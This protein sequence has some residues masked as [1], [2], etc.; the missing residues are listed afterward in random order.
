LS[1]L[2]LYYRTVRHLRPIQVAGRVWFNLL[3]PRPDLRAAPPL[4][5]ITGRYAEPVRAVPSLVGPDAFR[6]LNVERRC[7]RPADWQPVDATDLW[8]YNLH[9]FDDL[10]ARDSTARTEWHRALLR[11]WVVENPPGEGMAWQPYPVSR[12]IVNWVKAGLLGFRVPPACVESLAVQ[13]R[14]LA[15][16]LEYH[17]LGNHLLTNAKALLHAGMYFGGREGDEWIA[18]GLAITRDQVA[19]QVLPDGAHFELSTMYHASALEDLLDLVN[20]LRAYDRPIP[21]Q[22]L[23]AIARMFEWLS[24][25]THPDG[26]I[27]FFNDAAFGI[28]PPLGDLESY[29]RR[30]GLSLRHQ[31]SP[32]ALL[33]PSGYACARLETAFL[34]C[35][36]AEVGPDYLPAHA[37]ADTLS[38]ELSLG[39]R[40]IFVNSGTSLYGAT[41][42]RQRQRSTAAHN[43]VMIDGRD[44][45]EV[46]AGFR[47]GHRARVTRR[48][49]TAGDDAVGIE[50]AHDGYRRLP[51]RNGHRRVWTLT[52]GSLRI[53][54][55]VSGARHSAEARFHLH[56]G[57]AAA[58]D[59][60]GRMALDW[61]GG[62]ATMS[63]QHARSIDLEP[64]SW[65]PEFGASLPNTCIVA[66]FDGPTLVTRIDW[67]QRP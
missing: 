37:H 29:G 22:W 66:R 55:E 16:R 26:N 19:E 47:V 6:F 61:P 32:L 14:W 35:D 39:D 31:H 49:A 59:P 56:P 10:N 54:D 60:A 36:C 50:G 43:T 62:R 11:R 9:Y 51:G 12:R 44:S 2:G 52:P 30:L 45:S 5:A 67:T 20:L 65:H 42:E 7:S 23:P 33:E 4:R 21:E 18:R 28:A 34:V 41:P 53:E 63:F 3:K 27:A 8:T 48:F 25:M 1:N 24:A 15:S 17:L 46:W 58:V 40:R 38:F 64:T 57:V 13:A